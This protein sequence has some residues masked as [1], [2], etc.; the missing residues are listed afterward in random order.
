MHRP[1]PTVHAVATLELRVPRGETGDLLDGARA[2][3]ERVDGVEDAEIQEV[4]GV[5]PSPLDLYVTARA[6]VAMAPV[7][8]DAA[9]V[10]QTLADGF[11]VI[12][13]AAVTIRGADR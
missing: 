11:G 7:H 3:L 4:E 5:R 9:G 12:D 1:R 13:V 6:A 2:L 10:R 8:E